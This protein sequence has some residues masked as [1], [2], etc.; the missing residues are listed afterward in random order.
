MLIW[1][2]GVTVSYKFTVHYK[3]VVGDD[4]VVPGLMFSAAKQE[5]KSHQYT[6]SNSFYFNLFG[7]SSGNFRHCCIPHHS[8]RACPLHGEIL[9]NGWREMQSHTRCTQKYIYVCSLQ[10]APICTNNIGPLLF[11]CS[12]WDDLI[13]KQHL[14]LITTW[15]LR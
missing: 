12:Q 14:F 4:D 6:M 8:Y 7:P 15:M 10:L 5:R 9:W 2:T 11:L 13:Q 1:C 3:Y